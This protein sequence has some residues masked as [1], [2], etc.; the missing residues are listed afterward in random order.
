VCQQVL[1]ALKVRSSR[2]RFASSILFRS[3]VAHARQL[4]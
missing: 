2:R 4:V 3:N 1:S